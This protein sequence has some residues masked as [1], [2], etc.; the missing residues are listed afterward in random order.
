[1][2][3]SRKP[4]RTIAE[5]V[6][7][8]MVLLPPTVSSTARNEFKA[9]LTEQFKEAAGDWQHACAEMLIECPVRDAPEWGYKAINFADALLAVEFG[10]KS[11]ERGWNL[12]RT[13]DAFYQLI[14]G[15]P[16]SRNSNSPSRLD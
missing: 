1:M 8:L 6:K 10:L 16:K 9:M 5:R 14:Y 15:S 7:Y 4:A 2:N 12:E 3:D 11:A 13:R